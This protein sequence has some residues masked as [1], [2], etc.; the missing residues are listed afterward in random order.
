MKTGSLSILETSFRVS[1]APRKFAMVGR[2]Y[3]LLCA[4]AFLAFAPAMAA[5]PEH[6]I[7][8]SYFDC[9]QPEPPPGWQVLTNS[10]G[11]IGNSGNYEPLTYVNNSSRWMDGGNHYTDE[12]GTI[13]AGSL[14]NQVRG[15]R[16]GVQ[17]Y[18]IS[19]YTFSEDHPGD[20][21]VTRG[22]IQGRNQGEG[23]DM[24]IYLNN[25]LK[26]EAV[27]PVDRAPFLFQSNLGPIKKGDTVYLA[28][29]SQDANTLI[30]RLLYTIESF[31]QGTVPPPPTQA[32]QPPWDAAV[33]LMSYRT[34]A[35]DEEYLKRHKN[36][37]DAL[38]EQGPELVF[39]GDSITARLG[40]TP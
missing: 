16:D 19:A 2:F 26:L 25:E 7:I 21:W 10:L 8:A 37:S 4:L 40:T 34:V 6:E 3:P 17:N 31:P 36:L 33:P 28:F 24:K 38:L 1:L 29:A 14:H 9:W 39:I 18:A 13:R 32:I 23:I 20:V 11:P 12:A 15:M 5:E 22:N 35:P 27:A 30:V